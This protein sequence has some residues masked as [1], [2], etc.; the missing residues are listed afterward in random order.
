[1]LAD[2]FRPKNLLRLGEKPYHVWL[3]M[4]RM[5]LKLDAFT[6]A[7]MVAEGLRRGLIK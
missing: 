1:M 3:R 7:H 2:G 6:T 5:K 4:D